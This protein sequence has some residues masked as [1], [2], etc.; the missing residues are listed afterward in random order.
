MDVFD[1]EIYKGLAAAFE[2][3]MAKG[4]QIGKVGEVGDLVYSALNYT[5]TLLDIQT[6]AFSN[7]ASES[8][9]DFICGS[10]GIAVNEYLMIGTHRHEPPSRN[11]WAHTDCAICSFP[12]TGN[13]F[14]GFQLFHETSGCIYADDS[15][16]RQ[17][18]SVKTARAIA[19]LYYLGPGNLR[20]FDGGETAIYAADAN[21]LIDTIPPVPN[22]LFAFEISP[23]SYHAYLGS[24]RLVRDSIIWW[25]HCDIAS[26]VRRKLKLFQKKQAAGMDPW[27]RWTDPSVAKYD[28]YKSEVNYS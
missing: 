25:Y 2:K 8:L 16:D 5:P 24:P 7:I 3:G 26:L 17:P 1:A 10:F 13:R 6:T 19:C 4:K 23:Y 12:K 22:S 14:N 28:A 15:K 20:E 18:D 9:R 21:A 11:G 27:D